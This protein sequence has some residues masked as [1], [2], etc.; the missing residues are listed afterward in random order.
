MIEMDNVVQEPSTV[1]DKEPK[2]KKKGLLGLLAFGGDK[3]VKNL[4][5]VNDLDDDKEYSDDVE[6][7]EPPPATNKAGRGKGRLMTSLLDDDD[8]EDVPPP[9]VNE[10]ARKG[11]GLLGLL[12]D[13]EE[14]DD[15]D[16][17]PSFPESII[18]W[19][20][21]DDDTEEVSFVE[22]LEDDDLY[23]SAPI[24]EENLIETYI[25]PST[26][27]EDIAPPLPATTYHQVI[28][29]VV[30]AEPEPTET[31]ADILANAGYCEIIETLA[32]KVMVLHEMPNISL[33]SFG[34]VATTYKPSMLTVTN[35]GKHLFVGN[36]LSDKQK[37]ILFC[38]IEGL[39]KKAKRE[40]N[41]KVVLAATQ[42][43]QHEGIPYR[44]L[45]L[46]DDLLGDYMN[47]YNRT[48]MTNGDVANIDSL[49]VIITL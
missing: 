26:Q 42:L 3:E 47:T 43:V 24:D 39:V 29:E 23:S 19:D 5:H 40:G 11:G 17:V 28:E 15:S 35:F 9:P 37:I 20:D 45:L 25:P 33:E 49:A 12:D 36:P 16:N 7:S 1:F 18:S 21:E 22:E 48:I 31:R 10:P 13:D 30:N 6:S 14:D 4:G 27:E 44:T 32:T 34:A 2:K 8:D 38:Q 46:S 41:D